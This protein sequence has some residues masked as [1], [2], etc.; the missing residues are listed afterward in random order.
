MK[1]FIRQITFFL[2]FTLGV[3]SAQA[4][5]SLPD[6]F[7]SNM[8]LQQKSEVTFWGWARPFEEVTIT[9][10]WTTE[11]VKVQTGNQGTWQLKVNTPVAGGPYKIKINGYNEIVLENILIGEV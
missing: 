6:I 5:V 1:S 2:L 11:E 10:G 7:G 9:T 8:V 4:G 3:F